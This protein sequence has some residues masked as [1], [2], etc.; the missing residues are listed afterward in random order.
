MI[1]A[2]KSP[3]KA[4]RASQPFN[5]LATSTL[6]AL[7]SAAG[8]RSEFIIKHLPRAGMVRCQLPNGRTLCLWSRGDDWISNQIY[9]RGWS[10]YEPETAPL[11]LRLAAHAGATLDV[12]AHVGFYTL[13]AAHANPDGRV[14]AFEPLPSVY[15]RLQKNVHVNRLKNVCCIPSAVGEI[16][17]SAEFFHVAVEVPSSSSLSAEFMRAA[18]EVHRSIVPVL[19]VDRFARE[20]ALAPIDLVKIDTESTEP[21]VLRGM[22]ETLR[23]DHPIL[24]CEVLE[25]HGSEER[26]GEVLRSLGYYYYLLTRDGPVQRDRIEAHPACRNYL[27]TTLSPREV[28]QL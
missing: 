6:N 28:A 15:R 24:V 18:G 2:L 5:Y 25:G 22:R 14:F 9:Y 19:T 7:L 20:N 4:F 3:L 26:L 10:G 23:R 17:G 13:L 21:E 16:D 27:F 1:P 12:G 8:L 11:F